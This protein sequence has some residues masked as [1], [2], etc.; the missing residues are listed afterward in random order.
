MARTTQLR[1]RAGRLLPAIAISGALSYFLDPQNGARRRAEVGQ[2]LTG[3]LNSL[4]GGAGRQANRTGSKVQGLAQRAVHPRS[5][6]QPV[7]DDVTLARK[8]ETEIFRDPDVPKGSINVNAENGRIF[9]R[10]EVPT[11]DQIDKLA[12]EARKVPGVRDVENLLHTPGEPAPTSAPRDAEDVKAELR[13]SSPTTGYAASP[14]ATGA[15]TD[16]PSSPP[17]A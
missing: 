8:V 12:A 2:R 4:K 9:L 10:G 6:Q 3:L 13:E 11:A 16:G 17:G 5:S 15:S 1:G 14:A 7:E